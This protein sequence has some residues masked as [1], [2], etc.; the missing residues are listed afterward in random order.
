MR[1]SSRISDVCGYADQQGTRVAAPGH[2]AQPGAE[3][4]SRAPGPH[5]AAFCHLRVSNTGIVTC[6]E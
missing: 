5:P 4:A 3:M 2:G 6:V 1:H